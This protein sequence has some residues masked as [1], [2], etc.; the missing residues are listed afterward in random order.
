V[1]CESPTRAANERFIDALSARLRDL[2]ASRPDLVSF[3]ETG[4]KEATAFFRANEWLYVPLKD[5]AE[6][7]ATVDRQIA[8]R[9]GMVADLDD[10][11]P[12]PSLG[13]G[14]LRARWNEA[15]DA[16][17]QFPTG[18]FA[19]KDGTQ[20]LVRV[21]ATSSGMGASSDEDL[22]GMVEG[23]VR[24]LS[25]ASYDPQMK[26]GF[27]GDIA[28]AAAEKTSLVR[29]AILA[30]AVA[31]LLILGGIVWFYRSPWSLVLVG[32]PPL[33]GVGCAYAFATY[34]Y[35]Y[36]N[37]SG[38]FLGAIILG[39]GV[40]YP[41]VLYSRYREFRAR[42]MAPDVARR[43]AVANAFRAELVGA[44]VAA[45]AYGSLIVTRFRGFNQ[46]GVIGFVGMLMVWLS[47]IPCVPAL[48]VLLERAQPYLPRFLQEP[49]DRLAPDESRGRIARLLGDA[50]QRWA[51]PVILAA[52]AVTAVTASHLPG[53]LRDPWEYDF[54]KLGSSG[55]QN[56]GAEQTSRTADAILS[57]GMGLDGSL[58]LADRPE[59]VAEVKARILEHDAADPAGSLIESISTVD[60]F[61]PADQ[62]AKLE[63]L[64][65]LRERLT[66]AVLASLK[67]DE[68][69]DVS[70]LIPPESLRP[71]EARDL[72]DLVR[73]RFQER[74][75][76]LGT[77]LYLRYRRN[78]STNDGHN[79]LRMAAALDGVR[80]ADGTRVEPASRATVFAEMIRSLEHDGPLATTVSFLAVVLVVLV[81][82]SSFRGALGVIAALVLGVAWML[83]AAAMTGLRLN[84]LNFIALPITFGIGS[85]YPF[86]IFDRA[87]LLG[88]NVTRAVKLHA[89]TVALCS[90]TTVVG[91]GSL[92][93]ADNLAL[94]SFGRL[95]VA[96]E[97]SCLIAAVVLL[98][99]VLHVVGVRASRR[100]Q[101]FAEAAPAPAASDA[102]SA[103]SNP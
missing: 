12:E 37:A 54:D 101:G 43:E 58:I 90:Y 56:G 48:I 78:V 99:A 15:V 47:M 2:A 16:R 89:G 63:V 79:L 26:V 76:A 82:T 8:I 80:L 62:P 23:I 53:F 18:Y 44:L 38:A 13:L 103:L 59:Q 61:L 100:V 86:N 46:F 7:D 9:S 66:P 65:R 30:T 60:D 97:V 32:F 95:A 94:Q 102:S 67:P 57:G 91:Y 14:R 88:G 19:S 41:L 45:I 85:E 84:F 25:P 35:G 77:I 5:L 17:N 40:N 34:R 98:P 36:V 71:L 49:V 74:S 73:H 70:A 10:D 42:G 24:D 31:A 87:R 4:T 72:P 96:G 81:A 21:V 50:T 22:L 64:A 39:N 93:F 1:V 69:A 52:V 6:M 29:E 27:G 3:V 20:M 28:N 33:F 83:G 51:W 75:G 55:S 11:R 92:M 68:R